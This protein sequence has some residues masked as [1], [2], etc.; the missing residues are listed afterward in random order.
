MFSRKTIVHAN[1]GTRRLQRVYSRQLP[2]LNPPKQI[3]GKR[4]FIRY[5]WEEEYVEHHLLRRMKQERSSARVVATLE[6]E[7]VQHRSSLV[8][9][10]RHV[11]KSKQVIYLNV[12]NQENSATVQNMQFQSTRQDSS[13]FNARQPL[14]SPEDALQFL[15]M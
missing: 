5:D 7:N 4:A 9:S 6:K 2:P 1:L 3:K 13:H 10:S 11:Q 12:E 15:L 14:R 8:V